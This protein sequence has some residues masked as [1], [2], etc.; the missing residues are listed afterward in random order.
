MNLAYKR[1]VRCSPDSI[2]TTTVSIVD[3]DAPLRDAL[4]LLV[5]SAGW[6]TVTSTSAEDFLSR[7][8]TAAPCCLVA[9]LSLPGLNGL[10]LQRRL[11]DRPD[12]PVIFLS[13]RADV[14]TAVQAM[15]AGALEVF[16]KPFVADALLDA[17]RR[18]LE[19]SRT[20]LGHLERARV[21]QQR[22]ESLSRRE[23]EVMGLVVSGRLNKQVGGEL[24]I[25]EI[26]VKVH[27]GNL[28]RKMQAG[29]LAELVRMAARLRSVVAHEA[30]ELDVMGG[31]GS[32]TRLVSPSATYART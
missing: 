10:E 3:A 4:E 18:A 7:P 31:F 11:A 30:G 23:R 26:T 8:R 20:T 5:R 32:V 15:K 6:R 12:L 28:M 2:E 24:G 22:Y 27:R 16:T 1:L 29:S 9:E 25:S 14:P 17:I 21:L 13:S 19:L